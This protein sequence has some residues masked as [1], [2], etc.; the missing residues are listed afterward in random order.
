MDI[1]FILLGS[2][3]FLLTWALAYAF[4]KLRSSS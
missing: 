4:E 2:G 3:F 1:A